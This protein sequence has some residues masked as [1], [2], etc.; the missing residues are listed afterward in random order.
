MMR[1]T[2]DRARKTAEDHEY[3]AEDLLRR[4]PGVKD[5]RVDREENHLGVQRC[6]P[7][8]DDAEIDR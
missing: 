4:K 2:V 6:A 8:I 3:D 1:F 7:E 5:L